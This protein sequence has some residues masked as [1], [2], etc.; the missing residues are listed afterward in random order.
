MTSKI[1]TFYDKLSVQRN[2]FIAICLVLVF[3]PI[4]GYPLSQQYKQ[5]AKEVL[6]ASMDDCGIN[7]EYD[8]LHEKM[9]IVYKTAVESKP[10]LLKDQSKWLEK[11][12]KDCPED[13]GTSSSY[14]L[15]T[16]CLAEETEARLSQLENNIKDIVSTKN[17]GA[18]QNI[19]KRLKNLVANTL[20]DDRDDI[21]FT[22]SDVDKL[23]DG[24]LHELINNLK[25]SKV[26]AIVGKIA[27]ERYQL[28]TVTKTK[29]P[30]KNYNPPVLAIKYE[31]S[32]VS[33]MIVQGKKL[34][35]LKVYPGWSIA[36]LNVDGTVK[37]VDIDTEH[38]THLTGNVKEGRINPEEY[39]PQDCDFKPLTQKQLDDTLF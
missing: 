19:Q 23:K 29:N 2:A 36:V 11:L 22:R 20:S 38:M 21:V 10:E 14:R 30:N 17:D 12:K 18:I 7:D 34:D 28:G 16:Q 31:G 32:F 35:P 13:F 33:E 9:E 1:Y 24:I 27:I 37:D 5:C 39:I 25:T 15:H 4:S 6:G 8:R 26:E 3:L